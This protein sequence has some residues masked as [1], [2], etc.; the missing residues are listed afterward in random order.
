LKNIE[1]AKT[2]IERARLLYENFED[3]SAGDMKN[4]MSYLLTAFELSESENPEKY[5]LYGQVRNI[6]S[7]DIKKFGGIFKAMD[8]K[9]SM[10]LR[11][12]DVKE[13]IDRTDM[14]LS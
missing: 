10:I 2:K 14:L 13:M 5:E 9:D 3:M 1:L 8:W 7:K 4:I 12:Q 11:K 6:A